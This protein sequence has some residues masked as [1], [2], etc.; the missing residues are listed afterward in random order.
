MWT[1]STTWRPLVTW[2]VPMKQSIWIV[3]IFSL[4]G[5]EEVSLSLSRSPHDFISF[6]TDEC[7]CIVGHFPWTMHARIH[8]TL[9]SQISIEKFGAR[10]ILGIQRNNAREISIR[11]KREKTPR[12]DNEIER[13]FSVTRVGLER[14]L[15]PRAWINRCGISTR[16]P[17]NLYETVHGNLVE[18]GGWWPCT[19]LISI[20]AGVRRWVGKFDETSFG[21]H[22]VG[23]RRRYEERQT[24]VE[25]C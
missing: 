12:R 22:R 9:V 2:H 11:A 21:E 13:N 19:V 20:K 10:S 23:I 25:T 7:I 5:Q 18:G 1:R 17:I 15:N 3:Q 6:R 8:I 4:R 24:W 14:A 16:S